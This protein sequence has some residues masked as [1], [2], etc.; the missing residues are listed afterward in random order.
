MLL[1]WPIVELLLLFRVGVVGKEANS[2]LEKKRA[3]GKQGKSVI[4][5]EVSVIV[6][7]R[8]KN[9]LHEV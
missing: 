5:R 1:A 6:V 7:W 8:K 4:E 3:H 2:Q 9:A